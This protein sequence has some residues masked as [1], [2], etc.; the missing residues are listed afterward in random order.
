MRNRHDRRSHLSI[1]KVRMS[2][3]SRGNLALYIAVLPA[4]IPTATS[5]EREKERLANRNQLVNTHAHCT[6]SCK[7]CDCHI[8][9]VRVQH[10]I[11]RTWSALFLCQTDWWEDVTIYQQ[12]E[13]H[14]SPYQEYKREHACVLLRRNFWLAIY[15]PAQA[16]ES[17]RKKDKLSYTHNHLHELFE[18]ESN[19]SKPVVP[20]RKQSVH[21][22]R[23]LF[24]Q[25]PEAS[26]RMAVQRM[27][28]IRRR[29]FCVLRLCQDS[30]CIR[31]GVV[32]GG[33]QIPRGE[34]LE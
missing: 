33:K 21:I 27:Q 26:R 28:H 6:Y 2:R 1:P 10:Y 22:E 24:R 7:V 13:Y 12:R 15:H 5:C 25:R 19:S 32:V 3:K 18:G 17:R 29:P 16:F 11:R 23:S 20:R 9:R 30:V 34:Q 31:I 4:A 14:R 8:F